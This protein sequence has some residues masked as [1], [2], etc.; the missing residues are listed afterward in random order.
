[1][2]TTSTPHDARFLALNGTLNT[3][4]LGGLPVAGGGTTRSGV[5]FRSDIPMR[6]ADSDLARLEA[7]D[8]STVVD[9]RQPQELERDQNSLA[10]RAGI[11]YQNIEI[12]GHIAND[13]QPKDPYDITAFYVRALDHAGGA[14]VRVMTVLAGAPRA[15]L[16]HCTAGKDRTGLVAAL[17][18]ESV[19]VDRPTIMEDFA[20]THDR[21]EPLRQRLLQDAEERGVAREDFVRLL[22]ATPDLL[23]PALDHLDERFGGAVQYLTG[24][25]LPP[26]VLAHLRAKL[27]G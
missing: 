10:A 21:I 14:F 17:L 13:E 11:D 24:N 18:L 26:E 23:V 2:S 4:D 5:F 19:G 27:V 7:L 20:L 3:R 16:F 25:G 22:G 12:W 1:M 15:A 9:L 6:L 8:L